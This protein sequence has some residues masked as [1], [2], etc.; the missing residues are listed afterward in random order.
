MVFSGNSGRIKR[1]MGTVTHL[2]QRKK[3]N[4][5]VITKTTRKETS[6]GYPGRELNKRE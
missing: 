4:N 3:K 1:Q 2:S 6:M 5:Q